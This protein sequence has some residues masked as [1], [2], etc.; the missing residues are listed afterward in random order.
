MKTLRILSYMMLA[1]LTLA[2]CEKD[3]TDFGIII[4][5]GRP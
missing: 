4:S 3:D 5:S 2:A 1:A